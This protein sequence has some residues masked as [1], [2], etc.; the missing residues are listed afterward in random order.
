MHI[1]IAELEKENGIDHASYCLDEGCPIAEIAAE[2]EQRREA[3]ESQARA[4]G[5]KV[6]YV[7]GL[8]T[9]DYTGSTHI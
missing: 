1:R 7:K 4:T 2:N 9:L 6:V 3:I 8:M 5:A